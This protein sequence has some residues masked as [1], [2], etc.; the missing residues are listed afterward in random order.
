MKMPRATVAMWLAVGGAAGAQEAPLLRIL[1][2]AAGAAVS[3]EITLAVDVAPAAGPVRA[4]TFFVD[5]SQICRTTAPP[6]ECRWDAG[7]TG[8]PRSL[9]FTA[10]LADGRRLAQTLRTAAPPARTAFR[11]GVHM[12]MV[13]VYVSDSRGQ[14]VRGL[15]ASDFQVAEDGVPQPIELVGTGERPASILLALDASASMESS[16][17]ELR[18]AAAGFLNALSPEDVII[19]T[20][21]N[22]GLDVLLRSGATPEARLDA[23]TRLRPSGGTA[24]YD[25]IIRAVDMLRSLP[26][27]RAIVMF[28]DGE[29]TRSRSLP[30]SVRLALQRNDVVLYL[31]A[32]LSGE[33]RA[34]REQLAPLAAE[35]G[36][37]AWFPERMSAVTDHFVDVVRHLRNQYVLAYA[38]PST[39]QGWRRIAVTLVRDRDLRV[40]S[41]EGYMPLT[42]DEQ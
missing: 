32:Q 26:P 31:I 9:R 38:S 20:A 27:P 15:S 23:L 33:G 4:V 6:F 34:V 39:R 8:A 24:L 36:G 19:V 25:S 17:Q 10:D 40:R 18:R 30:E 7:P 11:A 41:R 12:V 1:R 35:T 37:T 2:P 28:T 42:A 13:P 29:D 16:L 3:G 5:G 21:F 14:F 22:D